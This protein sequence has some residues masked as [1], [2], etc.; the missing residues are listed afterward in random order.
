MAE[1]FRFLYAFS[2]LLTVLRCP[3]LEEMSSSEDD[4]E[5]LAMVWEDAEDMF[6]VADIAGAN[7]DVRAFA[8]W[9]DNPVG[10]FDSVLE[11]VF[12]SE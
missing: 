10:L 12:G 11:S 8:E 7:I 4:E 2:A 3:T 9:A 5:Q 1:L 6:E